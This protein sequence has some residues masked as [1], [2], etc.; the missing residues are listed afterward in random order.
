MLLK[1]STQCVRKFGKASSGQRTGR[2]QSSSQFSRKA[3]LKNVQATELLNSSPMSKV[4]LKILQ[5]RLQHYV[6]LE[7]PD[8]QAAFR[9]VR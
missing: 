4:M 9:K 8:V 1:C 7:I 6:N 5:A 3:V 2:G